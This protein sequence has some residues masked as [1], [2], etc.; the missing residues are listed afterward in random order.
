MLRIK[1]NT[2]FNSICTIHVLS[3][4][5]FQTLWVPFLTNSSSE[6]IN[7]KQIL[8]YWKHLITRQHL[9]NPQLAVLVIVPPLRPLLH[10]IIAFGETRWN[11]SPKSSGN[12]T[13]I[14][15]THHPPLNHLHHH[16]CC[17]QL[18]SRN[19]ARGGGDF[20]KER[21]A[22]NVSTNFGH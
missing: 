10:C 7:I 5:Y 1:Y 4:C 16:N 2:N 22:N 18:E 11:K 15:G 9:F 13:Q 14:S 19:L 21:N 3:I 17:S 8:K 6:C 12:R 20:E